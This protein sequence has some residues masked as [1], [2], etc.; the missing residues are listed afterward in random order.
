MSRNTSNSVKS[1]K[2]LLEANM[3]KSI[4]WV[5]THRHQP[6]KAGGPEEDP[7]R[8]ILSWQTAGGRGG[9]LI[10]VTANITFAMGV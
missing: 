8:N 6:L 7:L 3:E 2:F 10:L 1:T 9:L 5:F 4:L